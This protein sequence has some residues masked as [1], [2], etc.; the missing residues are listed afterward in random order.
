MGII[1]RPASDTELHRACII[2]A[3]AYADN[4]LNPVLFPGPFPPDSQQK[5][6]EQLIQIR[7]DDPTAAYLQAIDQASGRMIAFAKWHIY[8]T[9][10]KASA[11]SRKLEFGPGTNAE[12]CINFFGGMVEKKKEIIGHRPHICVFDSLTVIEMVYTCSDIA[13]DLHM[14]HTDPAYQGRGAGGALMEWG[15]QKADELGLPIYL[16]SSPKGH[17]FY[18]RHGFKDVKVLDIDLSKY[19]SIGTYKQPLMMREPPVSQ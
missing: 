12:A 19:G 4:E 8:S 15:T 5:R 17:R 10:E 7:K 2:E 3:A 18:Q 14:L 16:E 13:T 9:P 6:I 11:P 1:V